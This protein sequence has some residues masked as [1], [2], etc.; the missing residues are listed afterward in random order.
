MSESW[1]KQHAVVLTFA[2]LSLVVGYVGYQVHFS[3]FE[4]VTNKR[5]DNIEDR[6]STAENRKDSIEKTIVAMSKDIEVLKACQTE[7]QADMKKVLVFMA[8][9]EERTR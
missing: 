2:A 3:D 1:I 4:V 9:M 8:R 7:V 5:L 6:V